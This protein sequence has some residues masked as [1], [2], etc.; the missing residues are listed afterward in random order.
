MDNNLSY[1]E[2]KELI[3]KFLNAFVRSKKHY[4]SCRYYS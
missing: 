3:E 4:I 2:R 1:V